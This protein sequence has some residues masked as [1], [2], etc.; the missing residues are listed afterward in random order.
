MQKIY[1]AK[2]YLRKY[3]FWNEDKEKEDK[4]EMKSNKFHELLFFSAN[5]ISRAG[6]KKGNKTPLLE[7]Y[8]S[9]RV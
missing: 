4:I 9:R 2:K 1:A 5:A 3:I 6:E 7:K 8:G